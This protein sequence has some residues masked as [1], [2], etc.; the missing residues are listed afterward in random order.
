MLSSRYLLRTLKAIGFDSADHLFLDQPLMA[1]A[2]L[3]HVAPS[4]IYRPTDF[5][6]D[7][8]AASRERG[9]LEIADGV[10]A[11]S[12]AVL[13]K[14]GLRSETPAT[15]IE[16]GVEYGRFATAEQVQRSGLVYV[17]ALDYRFDWAVVRSLAAELPDQV[18]DLAG[19]VSARVPLLPPN[20][21]LLGPVTYADVPH[22][23]ARH[24]IGLLP[25][26]D[27][28][29]NLGRSPMK[30]F[31]YLASGLYVAASAS[32]SHVQRDLPGVLHFVDHRAALDSVRRLLSATVPNTAGVERAAGEGWDAKANELEAFAKSLF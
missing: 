2:E 9:F 32:P 11:T 19:P 28:P 30:L 17:G 18:F 13:E 15:V 4:V 31:E 6:F 24:Q 14:L 20:V 23:L 5:Y 8:I 1:H 7:R 16:N 22:L 3:R 12:H 26:N 25:F 10:A 21:R 27:A 29:T